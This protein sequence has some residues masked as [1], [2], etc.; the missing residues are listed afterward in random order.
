MVPTGVLLY[1][2]LLIYTWNGF[3]VFSQNGRGPVPPFAMSEVLYLPLIN[4][5]WHRSCLC[6]AGKLSHLFENF[7]L[8]PP[9]NFVT[10]QL[11]V[12]PFLTT[13]RI[14]ASLMTE[15]SKQICPKLDWNAIAPLVAGR[16]KQTSSISVQA[17]ASS[18][19]GS[20]CT[21]VNLSFCRK[22]AC[23]VDLSCRLCLG[24]G[25]IELPSPERV[26]CDSA[27]MNATLPSV[28]FSS[29]HEASVCC[30]PPASVECPQLPL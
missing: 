16:G 2:R 4:R 23:F 13:I 29:G 18:F 24:F 10:T 22:T 3:G 11:W 9:V 15:Q 17:L 19:S 5:P 26:C 25:A 12:F 7:W 21:P 8:R 14:A 1:T 6:S 27:I 28:Q 30:L 20:H